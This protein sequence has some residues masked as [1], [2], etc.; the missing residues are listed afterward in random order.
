MNIQI[1]EGIYGAVGI[2]VIIAVLMRHGTNIMNKGERRFF[3]IISQTVGFRFLSVSYLLMIFDGIWITEISSTSLFVI[4]I[5]TAI[6]LAFCIFVIIIM[7]FGKTYE[8]KEQELVIGLID[9]TEADRE[10]GIGAHGQ[11]GML[12]IAWIFVYPFLLFSYASLS[13]YYLSVSKFLWAIAISQGL[14]S[15][16][17][18]Y[19]HIK[20]K[21]LKEIKKHLEELHQKNNTI[22]DGG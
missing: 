13:I 12:L 16:F 9:T 22:Q 6:D 14:F 10:P 7:Q 2:T 19:Q 3:E 1:L 18:Y 5:S 21:R 20:N 8:E 17:F 4:A 11:F 15:A